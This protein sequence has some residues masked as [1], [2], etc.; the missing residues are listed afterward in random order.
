ML[1]KVWKRR[2]SVTSSRPVR[3]IRPAVE[4]LEP[5]NLLSAAALPIDVD[6]PLGLDLLLKIERD[7]AQRAQ[8]ATQA[9]SS[10]LGP[11]ASH[12][13]I[14]GDSS[15]AAPSGGASMTFPDGGGSSVSRSA[16][17]AS[18]NSA[19]LSQLAGLIMPS[20]ATSSASAPAPKAR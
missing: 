13:A 4:E 2:S 5:R 7:N 6:D 12:V 9:S 11:G 19:L 20:P 8:L 14:A 15:G 16:T 3:R 18:S 1:S 17:A 10:V